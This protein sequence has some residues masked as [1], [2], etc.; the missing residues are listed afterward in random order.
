MSPSDFRSKLRVVVLAGGDSAERAVSLQSGQS[1]AAALAMAGHVPRVVDPA[2]GPLTEI[3]WNEFDAC[4]LALHGGAGED[5]RVQ[6]QLDALHVPY[7]GSH[8]AA[9]RLAMSKIASKRRF[10]AHGVPTPPYEW[11][12]A[13]QG[14]EQVARRVAR[15]DYPLVVKPD[16]QGSSVGVA[17][18][19]SAAGLAAALDEAR[20]CGGDCLAEP[21]V[22]GREFTVALI[23][24]VALPTIEILPHQ[25]V[26]SYD[27]KYHSATTEYRLDFPLDDSAAAAI[28]HAAVAAARALG[29][30]GLARVDVM[31]SD[32]GQPWVLEVNTIP[33][34]TFRSLAPLAA[35][36]AGIDMPQLCDLLVRRCLAQVSVS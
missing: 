8:A 28:R 33:G 32:D 25:T 19:E 18:V 31:L 12:R 35:A 36:R 2:N 34:M 30:C 5:G 23:D 24:D 3:C 10:L 11:I 1:V 20:G 16:A 6:R 13:H 4:F 9:S 26:F 29:T 7:T 22:R 14:V 17:V 15:L 27:A 21:L